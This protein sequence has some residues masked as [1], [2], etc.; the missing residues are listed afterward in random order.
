MSGT[1]DR[2]TWEIAQE[3]LD[4]LT[5]RKARKAHLRQLEESAS[6]YVDIPTAIVLGVLVAELK[7]H[8]KMTAKQMC[9]EMYDALAIGDLSGAIRLVPADLT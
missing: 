5:T 1:D 2:T 4:K 9:D 7:H 3:T 8:Q 6:D